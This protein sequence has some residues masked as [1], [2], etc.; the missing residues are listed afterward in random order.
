MKKLAFIFA[1][2]FL[3][4]LLLY[5]ISAEE[6][7]L[8]KDKTELYKIYPIRLVS[9]GSSGSVYIK[10]N[11]AGQVISYGS[12]IEIYGIKI[13]LLESNIDTETAKLKIVQLAEC[14]IDKDCDD[15][16]PCTKDYCELR[17]CKHKKQQGC[18]INNECKPKG[19]LAVINEKLS[20]CDGSLWVERK[21]YKE[22]C[23]E[24]YECLTN[25]CHKGYC[26]S[27]GYLK[28][29]NKM[30]PAWILI[31]IGT[32]IGIKG[33]FWLLTPKYTRRISIN[34]LKLISNK[35]YRIIGII[36]IIIA[37]ALIIWSLI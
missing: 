35:V 26:K 18:P 23:I 24:N 33:L 37:L 5:S 22:P 13:S 12:P 4:I 19:S 29:G 1:S 36:L 27:L 30:A 14:L 17:S 2:T 7:V 34:L 20:Y 32:L 6:L 28:G 31:L 8:Q 15:N 25:Y 10:I 16:I 3:M 11:E 21:Q 9:I